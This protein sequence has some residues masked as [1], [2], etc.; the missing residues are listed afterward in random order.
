MVHWGGEEQQCAGER[1]TKLLEATVDTIGALTRIA[2]HNFIQGT[3][4]GI[5]NRKVATFSCPMLPDGKNSLLES[6]E[7]LIQLTNQDP[8]NQP[9][10]R[11]SYKLHHAPPIVGSSIPRNIWYNNSPPRIES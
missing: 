4:A 1:L 11:H 6:H 5:P 9:H 8:A 10:L 3:V 2:M 7:A